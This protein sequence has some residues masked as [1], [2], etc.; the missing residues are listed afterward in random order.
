[1]MR[2]QLAKTYDPK[3]LEDRLYEKWMEGGYFHAEVNP[4]KKPFTIVNGWRGAISTRKSI[5]R[6]SP[7]RSSFLRQILQA[8][9]IWAMHLTIPCRIS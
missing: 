4:E 1:M 9:F 7:S 5:R 2:K 3:G 8:S 6:K